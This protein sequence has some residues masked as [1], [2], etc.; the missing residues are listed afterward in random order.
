M[1]IS[2]SR[3]KINDTISALANAF[4]L[5]DLGNMT[6]FLGININQNS[7]SILINQSDKIENL[8]DDMGMTHCNGANTPISDDNLLDRDTKNACSQNDSVLYRSAVGQLLHIANMTR[9]DIQY[10]VN[11]LCRYLRE[12][13]QNALLSLK[14]L[15]RYVSRT[16]SASITFTK[17]NK[18]QLTASSDSSWGNITS[19]KGT[20]GVFFLINGSPVAWW[21]KKQT[22]TAQSTC[23]AEY[24]A[25]T[26]LAV[27]A[28]W[29]HPLH[30]EIFQVKD[31]PILTEIDNTA[32]L[33]TAQS[34]KIS[35]R[36]RHFL[37]RQST[38]R[39]AIKNGLIKLN[40]TPSD[41]CK[42]DGLTKALQRIKHESF[43]NQINIKLKP[44][45]SKG[46]VIR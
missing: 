27:A 39:E 5:K 33:I 40:Y 18:P 12:P 44:S 9:P 1:I 21:S 28:Q 42:A 13:S 24:A 8:C 19:P 23:E 20:T 46:G 2:A 30:K 31:E 32:A 10:A 14:H 29:I 22:I 38:V 25:L 43:C 6:K 26:S 15:V 11:R 16:K 45:V 37:M 36:N 41:I 3:I 35:A 7:S 34:D 17:E 4:K